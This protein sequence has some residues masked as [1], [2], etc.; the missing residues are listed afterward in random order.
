MNRIYDD[1]DL[2]LWVHY[3]PSRR[4]R[5]AYATL[6]IIEREMEA[7]RRSNPV[8]EHAPSSCTIISRQLRELSERHYRMLKRIE[9]LSGED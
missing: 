3:G 1:D 4:L 2:D 9:N 5:K 7:V 6:D 8:P